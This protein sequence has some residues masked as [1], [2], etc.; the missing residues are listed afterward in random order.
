MANKPRKP[1]PNQAE[2][3]RQLKRITRIVKSAE[4]D[5][6]TFPRSIIPEAPKRITKK[7]LDD[8]KALTP[9]RARSMAEEKTTTASRPEE[10][11]RH[12]R[13]RGKFAADIDPLTGRAT[14]APAET[15][16]PKRKKP[17]KATTPKPKTARPSAS[18]PTPDTV[19]TPE[20]PQ[21]PDYLPSA[22]TKIIDEL[23]AVLTSSVPN[24]EVADYLLSLLLDRI[25]TEGAEVVATRLE[26]SHDR[27]I[28][29][30]TRA[31]Y[32]SDSRTTR[33][34]YGSAIALAEL[35]TGGTLDPLISI[36]LEQ[37]AYEAYV[38]RLASYSNANAAQ[39]AMRNRWYD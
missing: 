23:T 31:V 2:F 7:T 17:K 14:E 1:T 18:A 10:Y 27:S 11:E 8:L 25:Y 24:E 6:L 20:A 38:D 34:V 19:I 21:T 30:A 9:T 15:K 29:L 35:I 32:D 22:S 36:E 33:N 4:R 12:P 13:K 28:E 5:G 16:P 3:E 37:L 26:E 39:K